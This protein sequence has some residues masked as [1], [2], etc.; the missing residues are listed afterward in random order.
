MNFMAV[1]RDVVEVSIKNL[2]RAGIRTYLTLIG[3]IIGIAAIV[4]L[5]SVGQG[6]NV[7]VEEQFQQLGSNTIFIIPGAASM[8][9]S[10]SAGISLTQADLDRL[11]GIK[12]ISDV[13][14]IYA[15][16][17]TMTYRNEK[18]GISIYAMEAGKANIF[19][20]TG[21]MQVAEGRMLSN[22]DSEGILI[23]DS[24][25]KDLF[26]RPLETRKIVLINGVEYKVVGVIKKESQSFGGGSSS[27]T[28]VYMSLEAYKRIFTG[29]LSPGIVF[30]KTYTR[31]D[32]EDAAAEV[33]KVLEKN[34]GE[35]SI[36]VYSSDQLL[37]SINSVLGI[38]TL[39][40]VGIGGISLIVGGI[41]IMNAMITS[42]ME[43]TKEIGLMKALGASNNKILMIF[44]LE[45]SFIGA[46]GGAIGIVIGFSLSILVSLIG[47]AVGFSL[48]AYIGPEIAVGALIFSMFVGM[49]SGILPAI[50]AAKLD[51]VVAL[52]Y[53]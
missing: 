50:N 37:T 45:A 4:S 41:G 10:G 21:F 23:G 44:L 19:G 8:S 18:A 39:F 12:G 38:V 43:R 13:I 6:L 7:A 24:I 20:D 30:A 47:T 17:A 16:A 26:S 42:V 29:E 34:Y 35:K 53:E 52:R 11:G 33:K 27:N 48:V 40:L 2:R 28:T 15:G 51:P 49:I 46:I 3:V 31:A 5:L 1:D 32:V 36:T 22:N 14:P 9:G 25:S